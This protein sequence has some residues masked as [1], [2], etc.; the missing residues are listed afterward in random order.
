MASYNN[1]QALS[2]GA[3]MG[4]GNGCLGNCANGLCYEVR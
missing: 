4:S 3:D 1:V 2:N